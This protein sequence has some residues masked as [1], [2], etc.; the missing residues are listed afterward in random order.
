M[1]TTIEDG[2]VKLSLEGE[3]TIYT[4]LDTKQQLLAGLEQGD[5]LEADIS[6]VSEFDSAGLQIFLLARS[7]ALRA[8]KGLRFTGASAAVKEVL[9]LCRLNDI[10]DSPRPHGTH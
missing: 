5:A 6:G 4:A 7:E 1:N 3:L 8:R 2:T 9:A 10:V